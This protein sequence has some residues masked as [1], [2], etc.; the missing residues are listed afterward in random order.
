M[1]SQLNLQQKLE[2]DLKFLQK[3][4]DEI[5]PTCRRHLLAEEDQVDLV[6]GDVLQGVVLLHLGEHGGLGLVDEAP[7]R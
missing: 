4:L 6:Q 5:Y 2:K 3:I 7:V 1:F